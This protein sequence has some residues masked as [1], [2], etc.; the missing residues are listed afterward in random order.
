[1]SKLLNFPETKTTVGTLVALGITPRLS[2]NGF[3]AFAT[4]E[5]NGQLHSYE[6][7][8]SDDFTYLSRILA[9]S[10]AITGIFDGKINR[11]DLAVESI[12]AEAF[13]YSISC[14]EADSGKGIGISGH[15]ITTINTRQ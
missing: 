14:Y 1:M 12:D 3:K 9:S 13:G 10:L 15:T 11:Y 5:R 4:F 6:I 8:S 7:R 2:D